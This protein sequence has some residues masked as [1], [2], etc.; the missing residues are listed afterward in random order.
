METD[1]YTALYDDTSDFDVNIQLGAQFIK[2]YGF[3]I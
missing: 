3:R 1:V 2:G